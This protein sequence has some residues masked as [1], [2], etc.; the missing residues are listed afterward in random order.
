MYFFTTL[1]FFY[2][3]IFQDYGRMPPTRIERFISGVKTP[4]RKSKHGKQQACSR[5]YD[6]VCFLYI[7]RNAYTNMFSLFFRVE[8]NQSNLTCFDLIRYHQTQTRSE[9][10]LLNLVPALIGWTLTVMSTFHEKKSCQDYHA[11]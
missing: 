3:F 2:L 7:V 5:W 8:S 4:R 9:R 10:K 1:F 11:F 6:F